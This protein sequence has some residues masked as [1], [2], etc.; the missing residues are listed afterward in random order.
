MESSVDVA[1][2]VASEKADSIRH[3]ILQSY[4]RPVLDEIDRMQRDSRFRNFDPRDLLADA[5]HSVHA[6]GIG[7]L[8]Q[9][10]ALPCDSSGL[11]ATDD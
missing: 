3:W 8:Q 2:P 10:A 7:V 5:F 9:I 6:A 11:R 4:G 1:A